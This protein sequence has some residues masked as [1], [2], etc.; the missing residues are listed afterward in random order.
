MAAG[1]AAS[2]G[3][4]EHRPG[5]KEGSLGKEGYTFHTNG[6]QMIHSQSHGSAATEPGLS[7]R[8]LRLGL[9]GHSFLSM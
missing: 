5:H 2:H 9:R 7:T 6:H 1:S 4:G 8:A 3:D